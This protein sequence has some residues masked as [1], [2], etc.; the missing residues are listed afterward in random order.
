KRRA[1][2][3]GIFP[4]RA[5]ILRLMGAVLMEQND[6]WATG[7][8]YFSAESMAEIGCAREVTGLLHEAAQ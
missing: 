8:K 6:E 2:V 5:A 3:V 4:N 7:R 1:Q